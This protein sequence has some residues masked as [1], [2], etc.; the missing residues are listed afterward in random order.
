MNK[1]IDENMIRANYRILTLTLISKGLTI[2]TMESITSGQSMHRT[3]FS[4]H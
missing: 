4:R 2:T 3:I 1:E